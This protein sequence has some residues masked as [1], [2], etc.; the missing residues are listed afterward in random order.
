MN[1]FNL[2][3]QEYIPRLRALFCLENAAGALY[4]LYTAA[5]SEDEKRLHL[6]SAG[7]LHAMAEQM[8]RR[9]KA[10]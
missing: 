3:K 8:R 5:N 6:K 7:E 9:W 2:P 1:D 10:T 4:D